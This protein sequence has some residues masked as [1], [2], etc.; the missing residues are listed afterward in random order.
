MQARLSQAPPS[1]VVIDLI[2][3][4]GTI[5]AIKQG[6]VPAIALGNA[7][8]IAAGQQPLVD[9]TILG[10][11]PNNPKIMLN[12]KVSKNSIEELARAI[13]MPDGLELVPMSVSEDS[14][15]EIIVSLEVFLLTLP[16]EIEGFDDEFKVVWTT[17]VKNSET[18]VVS[19][20]DIFPFD[21]PQAMYDIGGILETAPEEIAVNTGTSLDVSIKDAD[22]EFYISAP[23][24]STTVVKG[25]SPQWVN[26]HQQVYWNKNVVDQYHH[27]GDLYYAKLLPI[28]EKKV[29]FGREGGAAW[30]D[31]IDEKPFEAFYFDG[32][33]TFVTSPYDNL[34]EL[35]EGIE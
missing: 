16:F 20:F 2:V 8:A 11:Y 21:T 23:F 33:C 7:A 19:L 24:V 35:Y 15:S 10:D 6:F 5:Q 29:T 3:S 27:N 13:N 18:N 30:L 14:K 1:N 4:L 34:E 12:F 31:L 17:Y 26:A 32:V 25:I 9:Y 22:T 28:D